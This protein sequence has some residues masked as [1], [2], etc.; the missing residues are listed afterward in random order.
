MLLAV[1]KN[2]NYKGSIYMVFDYAEYDLT[3]LM[4]SQKYTFTEPQVQSAAHKDA[5]GCIQDGAS[6]ACLPPSEG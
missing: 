4:E 2:N 5:Q 1:H 3:G 6:S